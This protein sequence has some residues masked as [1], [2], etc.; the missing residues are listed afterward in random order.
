MPPRSAATMALTAMHVAA[1]AELGVLTRV[2]LDKLFQVR[3]AFL[4]AN[5]NVLALPCLWP[6]PCRNAC[7]AS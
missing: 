1:F 2:Y 4:S 6:R 7:L 5:K 3:N